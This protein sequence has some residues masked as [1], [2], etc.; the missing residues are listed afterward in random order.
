MS[1]RNVINKRIW[2]IIC[3]FK[4]D[5]YISNYRSRGNESECVIIS[6]SNTFFIDSILEK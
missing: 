4:V 2:L 6:D 1:I 3:L 5:I